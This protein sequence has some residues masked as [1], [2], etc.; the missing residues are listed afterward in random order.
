MNHNKNRTCVRVRSGLKIFRNESD[1]RR[2]HAVAVQQGGGR[3]QLRVGRDQQVELDG[4]I[5]LKNLNKKAF[6]LS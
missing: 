6:Y 5:I 4:R 2:W 1:E 3:V